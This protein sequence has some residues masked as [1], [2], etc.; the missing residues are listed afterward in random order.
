[1]V[2]MVEAPLLL[3]MAL[4]STWPVYRLIYINPNADCYVLSH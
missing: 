3:Q 2:T 1:M 4:M